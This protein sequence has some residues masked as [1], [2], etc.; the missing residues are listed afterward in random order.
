MGVGGGS[1]DALR[2]ATASDSDNGPLHRNTTT[3]AQGPGGTAMDRVPSEYD[4]ATG[5]G[6]RIW[7]GAN[8][9]ARAC[10]LMVAGPE[11]PENRTRIHTTPGLRAGSPRTGPSVECAADASMFVGGL[12]APLLQSPLAMAGRRRAFRDYQGDPWGRLQTHQHLLAVTTFGTA[13]DAQ[14]RWTGCAVSTAR[15]TAR[16]GRRT[17]QATIPSAGWVHRRGG[18]L[19]AGQQ[20]HGAEAPARS[21]RPRRLR[22]G[23]RPHRRGPGCAG[24]AAHRG[25]TRRA[26]SRPTAASCAAPSRPGRPP[27]SCCSPAAAGAGPGAV[28]RAG[29]HL[30]SM[31]PHGP[32]CR[33][34]LPICRRWR[35]L[36]S[37]SRGECWSERSAGRCRPNAVE[38][39]AAEEPSLAEAR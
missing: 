32:G 10:S 30:V 3:T 12:R 37:G 23:H 27:A 13:S 4:D 34:W 5:L 36:R 6:P 38:D 22:R 19:P 26:A 16:P 24:P 25:R 9:L 8:A 39:V 18:Q 17:Y 14:R 11:G 20:R 7:P 2:S 1:D 33:C 21:G 35:A 28:R 31:L 29:R 15:C